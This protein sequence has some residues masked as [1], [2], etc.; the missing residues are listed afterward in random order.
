MANLG[1]QVASIQCDS[2]SHVDRMASTNQIDEY[3]ER[4]Q[5]SQSAVS[6][7]QRTIRT[8]CD[9]I[10]FG[11]IITPKS[12]DNFTTG[13]SLK[14]SDKVKTGISLSQSRASKFPTIVYA[15]R[16]H[17]QIRQ[18]IQELKQTSYKPKMTVLGSREQ[19][20][21]HKKKAK[22]LHRKTQTDACRSACRRRAKPKHQRNHF[23][24]VPEY[25][26]HKPNLGEEPVDIEDL[27]FVLNS[28]QFKTDRLP[29]PHSRD[30]P[31]TAIPI[32]VDSVGDGNEFHF[33]PEDVSDTLPV[34][35]DSNMQ[36]SP[37]A[38][39]C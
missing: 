10:E 38:I 25:L 39:R 13:L 30:H 29:P 35:A 20:C 8:F 7:A 18:V 36:N 27:K 24:N 19:L 28:K 32:E 22:S 33:T 16:T 2:A 23:Q 15:S 5:T 1:G 37:S 3:C 9:D 14:T 26:K 11:R 6:S 12:L 31:M 17:S 21:I 4:A 34:P